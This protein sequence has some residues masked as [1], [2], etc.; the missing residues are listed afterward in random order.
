MS[1]SN[2]LKVKR[3]IKWEKMI[4]FYIM[5]IPGFIY[6]II[7]NYLPMAGLVMA[8]QKVNFNKGIFGGT[9]VGLKNFEYLFSSSD[10]YII[11]RNTIGYNV[12]FLIGGPII[13][14]TVAVFLNEVKQKVANRIYQTVILMPF[15]L[16]I[17]VVSY[18]AYAFL[19]NDNGM[20]NKTILPLLGINPVQWYGKA[21]YWPF[22]LIFINFWMSFG[23]SSVIYLASIVGIS[24]DYYEAASLDGASKWYQFIAITLPLIKPT[25][26]TMTIIGLGAIFRSNFG[27]FYQVPLNN[28]AL[29]DATQTIDTYVFRGLTTASNLGLSAAAGFLQSFIG[30]VT[31]VASNTVI[32]KLSASDA[33][34]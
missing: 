23:F 17:T 33:L 6:L 11:I 30:L 20:L 9:W 1:K 22:I 2:V 14:I 5:T 32:K 8:F 34:F 4:P 28:G 25:I 7:N 19:S 15:L 24:P 12:V 29:F 18:L 13:G 27:L 31:V 3:K 26:I 21:E 10:L 16:S